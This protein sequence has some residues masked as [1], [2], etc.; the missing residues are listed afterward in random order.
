MVVDFN[1]FKEK[2]KARMCYVTSNTNDCL[3]KLVEPFKRCAQ[4]LRCMA[5]AV[6]A[7]PCSSLNSWL[8]IMKH[9][10]TT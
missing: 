5:A 2:F 8:K 9:I 7:L 1:F 10:S 6:I 4:R 3:L